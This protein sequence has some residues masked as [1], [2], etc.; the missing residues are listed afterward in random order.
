[1]NIFMI[2]ALFF[3]VL[4]LIAWPIKEIIF[5]VLIF[6]TA[7]KALKSPFAQKGPTCGFYALLKALN[8]NGYNI[9]EDELW[10][11]IQSCIKNE[12]SNVGEIFDIDM[13]RKILEDYLKDSNIDIQIKNINSFEDLKNI[14]NEH[15]V[16]IPTKTRFLHWNCHWNCLWT[17]NNEIKK[18]GGMG[19]IKSVKNIKGIYKRFLK[20]TTIEGKSFGW[21]HWLKKNKNNSR[22]SINVYNKE[23]G[24]TYKARV[25]YL[26]KNIPETKI[27][28]AGRIVIIK[29][30]EKKS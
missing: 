10:D 6:W 2:K 30:K 25:K 16:I 23:I 11:I 5:K 7:K 12:T 19:G 20:L 29:Q 24:I 28:V 21:K 17:E 18:L 3:V 9:S 15:T 22:I 27:N 1:M 26:L 13:F 8:L 4:C 14:I